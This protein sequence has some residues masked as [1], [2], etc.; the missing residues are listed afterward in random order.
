MKKLE[1][2]YRPPLAPT[3]AYIVVAHIT[4]EA[5]GRDAPA[6]VEPVPSLARERA[7]STILATLRHL[8]RMTAPR[9][10]ERL[11]SLQSEFWSFVAVPSNVATEGLEAA[12]MQNH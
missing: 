9:S 7:P 12:D 6:V 3:D 2:R 4:W 5:G 11:V 10:F 8:V 1:A